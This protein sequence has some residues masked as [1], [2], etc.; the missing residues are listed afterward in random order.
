[1]SG[2]V[3][4][5]QLSSHTSLDVSQTY[6]QPSLDTQQPVSVV[7]EQEERNSPSCTSQTGP[8]DEQHKQV[9]DNKAILG[10]LM[11]AMPGTSRKQ[12]GQ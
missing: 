4:L 3:D 1:M 7:E 2:G 12:R 9:C 5:E 11:A 6:T 8:D 10:L